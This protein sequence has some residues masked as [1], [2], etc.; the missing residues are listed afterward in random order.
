MR[1]IIVLVIFIACAALEAWLLY[2]ISHHPAG[3]WGES[4]QAFRLM[5]LY[6]AIPLIPV[7]IAVIVTIRR[8]NASVNS[9]AIILAS[10]IGPAALGIALASYGHSMPLPMF[11]GFFFQLAL[12]LSALLSRVHAA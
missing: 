10:A 11:L 5:L 9:S 1:P 12:G 6:A 8:P 2:A 3:G 7:F 4:D